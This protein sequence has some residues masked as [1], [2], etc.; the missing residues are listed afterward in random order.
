MAMTKPSA[1]KPTGGASKTAGPSAQYMKKGGSK[2]MM[3]GGKGAAGKMGVG[4]AMGKVQVQGPN[5]AAKAAPMKKGGSKMS[6]MKK[7]M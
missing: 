4:G 1:S 6:K 3:Y 2:K 7:G 5:K